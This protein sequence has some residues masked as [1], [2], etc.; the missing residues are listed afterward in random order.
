[1]YRYLLVSCSAFF[2]LVGSLQAMV[3]DHRSVASFDRIPAQYIA[4]AKTLFKIAYGHT[5]HGSQVITGMGMLSSQDSLFAYT[6]GS[7][8]FM[9]DGC[10]PN[11]SDL[12]N[13]D[14]TAWATA[15]R[16]YLEGS[17]SSRN[18][19][20]WS[21]CGQVSSATSADIADAYLANMARLERDFPDVTFIYMTGHLDGSGD[22]GNLRTRNRQIREYAIANNKILFD[23]EDIESWDPG[24]QYYADES[25]ACGWCSA[26]CAAHT[27]PACGSCAHS[28]CFNCYNKGKAF[29]FMMAR[30]AGWDG[31]GGDPVVPPDAPD[32][33]TVQ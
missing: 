24:G 2:A 20:M 22:A 25:D 27:C 15:T 5:S 3:I 19:I 7:S 32:G 30:L 12:G 23:F 26:W 14:R 1:M 28:Q 21:W 8:G 11:A 33:L 6:T 4:A 10:I 9:C 29:W 17:G 18:V 16:A 31:P 13:P